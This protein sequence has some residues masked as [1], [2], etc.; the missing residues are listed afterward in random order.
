MPR[1]KA[2]SGILPR[3]PASAF[4]RC[5][6]LRTDPNK[7][8]ALNSQLLPNVRTLRL[9]AQEA[10]ETVYN[11]WTST[12]PDMQISMVSSPACWMFQV[13]VVSLGHYAEHEA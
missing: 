8:K 9:G 4:M 7:N 12:A 3:I 1:T 6:Q 5:V 11:T 10:Y 2:V 13:S